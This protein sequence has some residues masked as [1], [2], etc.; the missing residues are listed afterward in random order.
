MPVRSTSRIAFIA[1]RSGTRGRRKQKS[2]KNLGE[3]RPQGRP[4]PQSGRR[5]RRRS[6]R[7]ARRPCSAPRASARRA[8]GRRDSP[9][10]APARSCRR[11]RAGAGAVRAK[12]ANAST[13]EAASPTS[14]QRKPDGSKS[15]SQSAGS[16]AVD[17]VQVAHERLHARRAPGWSSRCQSR[18]RS[19]LHSCSWASSPPMNRSFLPGC[20]HM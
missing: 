15:R 1:S 6:R 14:S 3:R 9:R 7:R 2:E 12:R 5:C 13:F 19:W 10:A 17:P 18:L 11:R 4:R 20:A 8:A 16:V